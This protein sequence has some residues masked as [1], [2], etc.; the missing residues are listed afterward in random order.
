MQVIYIV[1]CLPE[2][3]NN[4]TAIPKELGKG[5]CATMVQQI[6]SQ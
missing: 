3:Q 5:I 4:G 6:T 2:Y 1:T